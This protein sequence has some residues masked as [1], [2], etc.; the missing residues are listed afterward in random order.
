MDP[1]AIVKALFEFAKRIDNW[2]YH[3]S[4]YVL[5]HTG[6]IKPPVWKR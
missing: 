3:S 5:T 1:V 2:P 4:L 6:T